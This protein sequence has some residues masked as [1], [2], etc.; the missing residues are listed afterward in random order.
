MASGCAVEASLS[1]V[2]WRGL[3]GGGGADM[4][5]I[6]VERLRGVAW[7]DMFWGE[8]LGGRVSKEEWGG[9]VA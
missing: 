5:K 1:G 9:G 8:G 7:L 3:V 2:S 4:R 6:R